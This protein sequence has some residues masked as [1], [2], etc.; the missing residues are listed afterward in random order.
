VLIIGAGTIRHKSKNR[1]HG[2]GVDY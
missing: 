2:L 1:L